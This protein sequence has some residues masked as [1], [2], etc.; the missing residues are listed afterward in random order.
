MPSVEPLGPE[1]ARPYSGAHIPEYADTRIVTDVR[2]TQGMARVDYFNDR[3]RP[4]R[5]ASFPP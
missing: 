1:H 4:R 3:R 2:G 5:T